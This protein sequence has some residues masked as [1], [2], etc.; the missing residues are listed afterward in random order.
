MSIFS[1][2]HTVGGFFDWPLF[3]TDSI[4]YR[5]LGDI[6][7]RN[8]CQHNLELRTYAIAKSNIEKCHLFKRKK[9]CWELAVRDRERLKLLKF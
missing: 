4:L 1:N 2:R 6:S 8:A 3:M 7:A 9:K 5:L